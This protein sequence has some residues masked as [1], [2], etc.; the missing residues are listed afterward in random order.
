MNGKPRHN[1]TSERER[2]EEMGRCRSAARFVFCIPDPHQADI[3][4]QR[5]Q[6]IS[7]YGPLY[8]IKNNQ[9][10]ETTIGVSSTS[11]TLLYANKTMALQ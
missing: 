5:Q 6:E 8:T 7:D 9:R 10:N 1:S 4:S 2:R 3:E 11:R